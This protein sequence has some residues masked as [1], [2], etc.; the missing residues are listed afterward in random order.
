[1]IGEL[2]TLAVTSNIVFLCS[3][4]QLLVTANGVLNSPILVTL[5]VEALLP[6]KRRFLEKPHGVTSQKTTF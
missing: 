4:P 2:E 1:M 3:L 5:M 6:L